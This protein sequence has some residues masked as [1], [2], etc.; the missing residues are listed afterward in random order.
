VIVDAGK[1]GVRAILSRREKAALIGR[2]WAANLPNSVAKK[3][4]KGSYRS[5]D[6]AVLT[7]EFFWL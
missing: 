2:S 4:K 7:V 6:S 1:D 5:R 3:L